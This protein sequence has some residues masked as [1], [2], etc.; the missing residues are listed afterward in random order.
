MTIGSVPKL[1]PLLATLLLCLAWG[2]EENTIPHAVAQG[3][4]SVAASS[5]K[6]AGPPAFVLRAFSKSD[7]Y[8]IHL[9]GDGT[10]LVSS[11]IM[12]GRI[13]GDKLEWD[14]KLSR[15]LPQP[16]DESV[17]PEIVTVDG[18]HLEAA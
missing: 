13:K 10:R 8:T 17:S 16:W 6:D 4:S 18:P 9:L 7:A 1:P 2:G 12:L 14:A 3:L 11:G 5:A 15:G